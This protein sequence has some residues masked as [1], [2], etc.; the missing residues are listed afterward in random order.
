MPK[1]RRADPDSEEDEYRYSP[2]AIPFVTPSSSRRS[3]RLAPPSL[4]MFS[5]NAGTPGAKFEVVED[6]DRALRDEGIVQMTSHKLRMSVEREELRQKLEK[7]MGKDDGRAKAVEILEQASLNILRGYDGGA[8]RI[9][10]LYAPDAAHPFHHIKFG[11]NR[12]W[13]LDPTSI[14]PKAYTYDEAAVSNLLNQFV[15]GPETTSWRDYLSNASADELVVAGA[16]I[17]A[18]HTVEEHCQDTYTA[19]PFAEVRW[20]FFSE[21]IQQVSVGK[22]SVYKVRMKKPD[23]E[24]SLVTLEI[25][26]SP[27]QLHN[28]THTSQNVYE[29]FTLRDWEEDGGDTEAFEN[30]A[31]EWLFKASELAEEVQHWETGCTPEE[32]RARIVELRPSPRAPP[33][34]HERR[35]AVKRS[36]AEHSIGRAL[37]KATQAS[38]ARPH[39]S[40]L[41]PKYRE[42]YDHLCKTF[43]SL[44]YTDDTVKEV[45][46]YFGGHVIFSAPGAAVTLDEYKQY[47]REHPEA[48]EVSVD[49]LLQVCLARDETGLKPSFHEI[50]NM[51]VCSRSENMAKHRYSPAFY[52]VIQGLASLE[53]NAPKYLTPKTPILEPIK[54]LTKITQKALAKHPISCIHYERS[55]QD[56]DSIS[57]GAKLSETLAKEMGVKYF[58]EVSPTPVSLGFS[59]WDDP[60]LKAALTASAADVDAKVAAIMG[61]FVMEDEAAEVSEYRLRNAGLTTARPSA[62]EEL[63]V[64]VAEV[65]RVVKVGGQFIQSAKKLNVTFL[66]NESNIPSATVFGDETA[67]D[68]TRAFKMSSRTIEWRTGEQRPAHELYGLLLATNLKRA[69]DARG[70]EAGK[71]EELVCTSASLVTVPMIVPRQNKGILSP[72]PSHLSHDNPA[73]ETG[74]RS[75]S[76]GDICYELWE[77]ENTFAW[78]AWSLNAAIWIGK[79]SEV[80]PQL[81][82]FAV[83]WMTGP[84]VG[85]GWLRKG[86]AEWGEQ[87]EER[88]QAILDWLAGLEV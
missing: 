15:A 13:S 16:G 82:K 81:V 67:I 72:S 31:T 66:L 64:E 35:W 62:Y 29:S 1:R 58:A 87:D 12:S 83:S 4:W 32:F 17:T 8:L 79:P 84:A 23:L 88:L 18:L 7:E 34:G 52:A 71:I 39:L 33:P 22:Y 9:P 27:S 46:S 2:H 75:K 78:D 45:R 51:V 70:D 21:G 85:M 28:P 47:A 24:N 49:H 6:V 68:I 38:G 74:F 59:G 40:H 76:V 57:D 53:P 56:Y 26:I 60:S 20:G 10:L 77:C 61:R 14:D 54:R 42:I 37:D 73:Y 69:V 50:F 44:S 63:E 41:T 86:A 43:I 30:A 80:I 55:K 36:L 11:N 48:N 25:V 19:R 3:S 5:P 65:E